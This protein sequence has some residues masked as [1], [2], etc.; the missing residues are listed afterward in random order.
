MK[1]FHFL[2]VLLEHILGVPDIH[3][4]GKKMYVTKIDQNFSYLRD[5]K[6]YNSRN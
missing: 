4:K 5:K 6:Q 3:T 1:H 2:I